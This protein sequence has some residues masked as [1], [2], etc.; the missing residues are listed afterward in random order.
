MV[1]VSHIASG[2][3]AV[4]PPSDL[5]FIHNGLKASASAFIVAL[6]WNHYHSFSPH[7]WIKLH[8]Y[9][10]ISYQDLDTV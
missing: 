10:D 4:L 5:P 6:I 3:L 8:E 1:L 7:H 9:Q 2:I